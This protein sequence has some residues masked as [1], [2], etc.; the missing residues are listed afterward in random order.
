[1]FGRCETDGPLGTS[2]LCSTLRAL[3]YD[4]QILC[5][6]YSSDVVK[7][8]ARGNPIL[9]TDDPSEIVNPSFIISVERP[10]RSMKT[11]DFRT[12]KAR[13]ITNVTAPLDLLFPKI[14]EKKDYV[15]VSV[16]DGGNEVGTG[17]VYESVKK[18][19]S[20]GEDICTNICCDDLV[21][22]GVSNWG[23]L[24]IA[25]AL[26]IGAEDAK[27]KDVFINECNHQKEI[28]SDMIKAGSFDGCTGKPELSIDGMPFEN[29]HLSVT[30]S[31]I[32]I[33]TKAFS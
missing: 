14:G 19:V 7:A 30:N 3:G 1:M 2:V 6:S 25:A 12:M 17:N 10:G 22:A 15:T 32:E 20:M 18:Y 16:G 11:G 4:T 23:A 29:E 5:D 24:G 8:A 28:L 21:M 31:I 33:V 13:D 27:A 9:V 26:V